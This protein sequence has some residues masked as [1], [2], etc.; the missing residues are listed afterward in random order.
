MK[1]FKLAVVLAGVFAAIAV[2][3]ASGAS[4]KVDNGPCPEPPGGG[5]LL[6]CPTGHV[7]APYSLQLQ[8][9][10]GCDTYWFEIPNGALPAGLSMSRSGLVTGVPTGAGTARFWVWIHDPTAAEGGPSWCAYDDQS[11]REFSIPID[12]GLAIVNDSVEPATVGQSYSETLAA[13]QVESL[14]PPTGP[15]VQ[16]AWSV[17]SG[18][19]PPGLTFSPDGALAGAPT[20]EGSYQFVVRAQNGG[21]SATATYTLVVRQPVVVKSQ[22]GSLK[23]PRAEVRIRLLTAATATGGTGTY[24][25]SISSGALPVG[26]ALDA[27]SGTISGSP[28]KA[29]RFGFDVSAADGEGRDATVSAVLT[30]APT[31]TIKTLHLTAAKLGRA[32]QAKLVTAGGV[33]PVSWTL[34]G[35]LPFGV[36]FAKRVGALVGT[37]R[38][39]GTFRVTVEARDALGAK[40][41]KTLVLLVKS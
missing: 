39:M 1:R 35:R 11:E 13:K 2:T 19:L 9:E 25:W 6:R 17:Q 34:R 33:Q 8:G 14:N 27:T 32:Y 24:A 4:F 18:A 7:G 10:E 12:P 29:G 20:V 31:L 15:D 28:Q 21:Q 26:V 38:R 40:S 36:R 3:G 22:F 37:P 23:P 41:Q 16:A 5:A 30:V